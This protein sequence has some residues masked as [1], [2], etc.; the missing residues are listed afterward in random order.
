MK[1]KLFEYQSPD[2]G[3][4]RS[5]QIK[6]LDTI[7]LPGVKDEDW[8]YTRV[9]KLGGITLK[10][11]HPAIEIK[12]D[13]VFP[14]SETHLKFVN[15]KLVDGKTTT[16]VKTWKEC[17]AAD[18]KEILEVEHARTDVFTQLN[19]AWFNEAVFIHVPAGKQIEKPVILSFVTAGTENTTQARI[20]IVADAASKCSI[21]LR[22]TSAKAENAF[23]NVSLFSFLHEKSEVEIVK[24]QEE[25]DAMWHISNETAVQDANS[26]FGIHTLSLNG[27]LIRNNLNITLKGRHTHTMLSGAVHGTGNMHVDNHSLVDHKEPDCVSD[28]LYKYILDGKSVGVFNGKVFVR[29]DAQKTLAYQSNANLLL[30]ED[31][32]INT[33]PELE[34]YADDVKCS[35]GTTTGYMDDN[36]L[37]YLRARGIGEETASRLLIHAFTSEVTD[38]IENEWLKAFAVERLNAYL[39]LE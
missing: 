19:D 35:H 34:I 38:R 14:E 17:S 27:G 29:Q 9:S 5:K 1:S 37:F 8:K 22:F 33:K 6:E 25:N 11:N 32:S 4:D 30:S 20:V 26:K 23:C 18:K 12:D 13:V 31:A 10:N 2:I 16:F 7:L 24:V 15:G 3:L 36:A 21:I 39:K 28:E